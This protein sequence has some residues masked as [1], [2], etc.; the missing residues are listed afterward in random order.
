VSGGWTFVDSTCPPDW[1]QFLSLQQCGYKLLQF[2]YGPSVGPS[3]GSVSMAG[4]LV[5][6]TELGA[7][8]VC[9]GQLTANSIP[10]TCHNETAS[11]APMCTM[12]LVR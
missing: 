9:L 4:A 8:I 11:G 7:P 10:V 12:S 1:P 2:P 5:F 6:N 3:V